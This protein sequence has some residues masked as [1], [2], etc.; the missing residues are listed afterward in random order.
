MASPRKKQVMDAIAVNRSVT[1]LAH[2]ILE[3]N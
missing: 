3:R 2:E 1:R